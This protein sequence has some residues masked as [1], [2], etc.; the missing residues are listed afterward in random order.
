MKFDYSYRAFIITSL[1]FGCLF[2]ILY[3]AKLGAGFPVDETSYDVEY[4]DELPIPEEELAKLTPAEQRAIETNKAFNEA[5]K[6]ISDLETSESEIDDKLAELDAAI[7]DTQFV[8]EEGIK[9]AREKLKEAREIALKRKKQKKAET[10]SGN[11]NTTISYELVNRRSLHI[12]NPVYTCDRGGI[13]VINIQVNA[14]GKVTK[15]GYNKKASST[16]N[17]CLI[18]SAIIYAKKA[19]FNTAAAVET[20]KGTIT[21]NF[22]GQQ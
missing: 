14:L 5:E 7:N 18:E 2:L 12:P 21:Y 15:T 19:R 11:R 10:G 22:P 1:L 17:G 3:S 16:Q 6:F 8:S 9:E 4:A 13:I 20:Q